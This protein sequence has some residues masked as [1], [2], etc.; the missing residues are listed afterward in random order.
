M[1]QTV[2][3]SYNDAAEQLLGL[4][5]ELSSNPDLQRIKAFAADHRNDV[6]ALL[7]QEQYSKL[8]TGVRGVLDTLTAPMGNAAAELENI[9]T[10]VTGVPRAELRAIAENPEN[11]PTLTRQ[12][13]ITNGDSGMTAYL[14][15][16]QP[17]M[18]NGNQKDAD[19]AVL[20]HLSY[21]SKFSD[22]PEYARAV[23]SEGVTVKSYCEG[24]L[25]ASDGKLSQIDRNYLEQMANSSRYGEM[26]IDHVYGNVGSEG[27][28]HTVVMAIGTGDGHAVFSIQGTN[29]TVEDW[30]TNSEFLGSSLT[31]EERRVVSVTNDWAKEYASIDITGHSQGGRE[32]VSAAA[33]MDAENQVKINRV[34]NNDGPGYSDAFRNRYGDKLSAIEDKVDNYLPNPPSGVGEIFTQVGQ[35]HRIDAILDGVVEGY[36]EN[37]EPR[38]V[39]LHLSTA[40]VIDRN[41]EYAVSEKKTF[42]LSALTDYLDPVVNAGSIILGEEKA[43]EYGRRLIE[44]F[45]SQDGKFGAG[46]YVNDADGTFSYGTFL[47]NVGKTIDLLGDLST[48][49]SEGMR[50]LREDQ[51]TEAENTLYL[52]VSAIDDC[53]GEI[54]DYLKGASVAL[55]ILTVCFPPPISLFPAALG[56]AVDIVKTIVL[57]VQ[58]V[59]KV[60]KAVL[61]MV[62]Y[63]KTKA[64]KEAREKY[65]SQN[66]E[67][68]VSRRG[69]LDG[70][71][72]LIQA[73]RSGELAYES[74]R[75]AMSG[76]VKKITKTIIDAFGFEEESEELSRLSYN[77]GLLRAGIYSAGVFDSIKNLK[78]AREALMD[79][80]LMAGKILNDEMSTAD[81]NFTV[82]PEILLSRGSDGTLYAEQMKM[83]KETIRE[84]LASLQN[85]W[86][87]EDMNSLKKFSDDYY[88]SLDDM[89][90]Q[91]NTLFSN[92]MAI[93]DAY[94]AFQTNSIEKFQNVR[95]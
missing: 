34:V 15:S 47:G 31:R 30:Q 42:S 67:M 83:K 71:D 18:T 64:K 17:Q 53:F 45:G 66:P 89:F 35:A 94:S 26:T 48:D 49:L 33:F 77:A 21:A 80:W 76:Y 38:Y 10:V 82:T 78:N 68:T 25:D 32:A 72:A 11:A 65:I 9:T 61:D 4:Q 51:L 20:S 63:F 81:E 16:S 7:E 22:S 13:D 27:G 84:E 6:A 14:K 79:V 93:A 91:L 60:I 86:V 56:A 85:G 90:E 54:R 58:V 59:C 3:N 46:N 73:Q 95:L 29:G 40:W 75:R 87:G 43:K 44:L 57:V 2:F 41:G 23:M 62:A 8:N 92:L 37:G 88:V 39:N 70:V 12:A 50:K 5:Q 69:L 74:F 55:K 24:L 28:E 1:S 36:D 52:T 19:Y